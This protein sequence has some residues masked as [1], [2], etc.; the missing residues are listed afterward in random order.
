MINKK[1]FFTYMS[2]LYDQD[3]ENNEAY[4]T[5]K[6]LLKVKDQDQIRQ[7]KNLI[8]MD[9]KQRLLY[10]HAMAANG[11]ELTPTEV[12]QYLSIIKLALDHIDNP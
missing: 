11:K 8:K 3:Y 10:R 6:S 12:D 4:K 2:S 9:T 1:D 7:L 5:F